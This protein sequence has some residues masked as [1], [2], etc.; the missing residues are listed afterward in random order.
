[1]TCNQCEDEFTH[2]IGK[3]ELCRGHMYAIARSIENI[4]FFE[5]EREKEKGIVNG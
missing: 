3:L 4:E 5:K 2:R 1:M